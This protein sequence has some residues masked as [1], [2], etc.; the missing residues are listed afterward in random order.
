MIAGFIEL[1]KSRRFQ[2][3]V[4]AGVAWVLQQDSITVQTVLQAVSGIL[5]SAVGVGTFD[6]LVKK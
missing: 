4:V 6:K 2:L 3:L 5:V 1:I